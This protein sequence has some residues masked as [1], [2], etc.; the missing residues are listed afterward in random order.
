M[1]T[2]TIAVL[3]TA[4]SI[5]VSPVGIMSASAQDARILPKKGA[6]QN[7]AQSGGETQQ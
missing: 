3:I 5:G 2:S 1:K 7:G 6:T 4:L